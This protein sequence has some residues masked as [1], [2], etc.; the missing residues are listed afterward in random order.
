M[1]KT[2]DYTHEYRGTWRDGGRCHIEIYE[3][4]AGEAVRRPVIVA[5][6]RDEN[7][8]PSVTHMAEYLAAAI[9]ARHFPHLLDAPT[10]QGQP[11]VWLEHYPLG[12]GVPE[13]YDRVT[14][15]PWRSRAAWLGG[16]LRRA[17]GT[18][19]WARGWG[20]GGSG[21]DRGQRGRQH[22]AGP[23]A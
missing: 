19:A 1:R 4:E 2:H 23:P 10:E 18:P 5:T 21:R 15:A 3:T 6:E 17:L 16:T 8:G 11:V 22:P 13:E 7:D 9:V 12:R 14:F 20:R